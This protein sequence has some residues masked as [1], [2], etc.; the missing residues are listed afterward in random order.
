MADNIPAA[1]GPLML[2]C[3]KLVDM[4]AGCASV[5]QR[6]AAADAAAAAA[7]MHFPGLEEGKLRAAMPA[8]VIDLWD[9]FAWKKKAGGGRNYL[10]PAGELLVVFADTTR[11]EDL[12]A[13]KRDFSNWV[14][15][16]LQQLSDVAGVS[17][18]LAI[19][20]ISQ[21]VRPSPCSQTEQDAGGLYFLAAYN[22]HWGT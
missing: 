6:F 9:E 22:V 19:D 8:I 14:G 18:N 16:A 3:Q 20:A 2:A 17:G 13:G 7:R 4:L 10:L 5:Q 21:I 12:E 1:A 11:I 15:T